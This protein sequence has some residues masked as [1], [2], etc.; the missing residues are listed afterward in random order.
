[1]IVFGMMEDVAVQVV[2]ERRSAGR[3]RHVAPRRQSETRVRWKPRA[4][5]DGVGP[6]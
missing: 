3:P 6:R 5:R 2:R 1:M 4:D